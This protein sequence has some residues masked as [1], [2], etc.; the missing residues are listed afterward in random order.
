MG[1]PMVD[2][3]S[4]GTKQTE[5]FDGAA[6]PQERS[7][8]FFSFLTWPFVLA[9]VLAIAQ[10]LDGTL[11]AAVADAEEAGSG[12][13]R[14]G[15]LGSAFD[16][17]PNNAH[18]L[19]GATEDET[20]DAQAAEGYVAPVDR[21]KPSA[22]ETPPQHRANKDTADEGASSGS[23]GDN[24]SSGS[25]GDD[26]KALGSSTQSSFF[27]C[28]VKGQKLNDDAGLKLNDT[29]PVLEPVGPVLGSV[30]DTATDLVDDVGRARP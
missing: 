30:T 24:D 23:S 13:A 2:A 27:K 4:N 19:Q 25:S 22:T 6:R 5:L 14:P 7:R 26:V 16:A 17:A 1:L 21:Q 8:E 12:R 20:P 18:Q 28:Q 15:D 3:R 9:Q 10:F 11:R 29:A